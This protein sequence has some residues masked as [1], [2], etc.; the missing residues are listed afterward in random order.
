MSKILYI[1]MCWMI[2]MY[3]MNEDQNISLHYPYITSK[4]LVEETD[5]VHWRCQQYNSFL[6]WWLRHLSHGVIS[7]SMLH[8]L[9]DG[10]TYGGF[11]TGETVSWHIF[12]FT[13]GNRWKSVGAKFALNSGR[14][15]SHPKFCSKFQVFCVVCSKI[16]SWG[17]S[18]LYVKEQECLE[19]YHTFM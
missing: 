17:L 10:S 18:H 6:V 13:V 12:S 3:C 15:I 9:H 5:N 2:Y 8:Q 4:I 1:F 16:V 7:V 14:L 19:D 11:T